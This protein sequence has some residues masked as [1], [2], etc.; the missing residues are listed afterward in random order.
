MVKNRANENNGQKKYSSNK[1][2]IEVNS[3]TSKLSSPEVIWE[4]SKENVLSGKGNH[5]L[6]GPWQLMLLGDG[7]PTRHLKLLTG[8]EVA[9][10]VISMAMENNNENGVPEEVN[11]LEPPLIR[12]QVWLTCGNLTLA[13]AESWWNHQE[14]EKHLQNKISQS[15]KALHKEDQSCLEK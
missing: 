7:S 2:L 8:H 13:W 6:S 5:K 14:A 10:K 11:E 1:K 3:H 15:G 4:A 9:I 12:R